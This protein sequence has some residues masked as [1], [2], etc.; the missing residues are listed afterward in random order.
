M[1]KVIHLSECLW[2]DPETAFA[3]FT[4]KHLIEGWLAPLARVEPIVGGRYELFWDLDGQARNCTAGCRVTA[5]RVPH[6]I[7]F[8]WKSPSQFEHFANDVDPLTHVVVAFVPEGKETVVHLT[9][10]GWRVTPDWE[11]ARVW[12]VRAWAGAL[13]RLRTRVNGC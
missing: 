2:C 12:Q 3:N 11:E 13:T 10:S 9:H 6:L 5:V 1:N 7:A 8:E 4:V